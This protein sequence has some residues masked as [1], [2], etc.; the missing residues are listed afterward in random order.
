M[1]TGQPTLLHLVAGS[2]GAGKTTYAHSISERLG[3]VHLS[4]DGW[5]STLFGPDQPARPDFEWMLMRTGRCEE[6]MWQLI[7]QCV[8][9]GIPV[10]ADCGFTRREHRSRWRDRAATIGAA[11]ALHH[12]DVPADIRWQRVQQRNRQ[13]GP[14]FSF[15]VTRAMFDFIEGLWEPPTADE[16]NGIV[17]STAFS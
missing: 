10:V 8:R 2:T 1:T 15:E 12:L 9:L 5:M 11:V 3:A 14:S 7:A 16:L 13:K 4:I 17:S 6:Q